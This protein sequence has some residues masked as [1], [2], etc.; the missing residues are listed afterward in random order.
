MENR[1][2]KYVS[3]KGRDYEVNYL[4]EPRWGERGEVTICYINFD[5]DDNK[6][7]LLKQII[8]KSERSPRDNYS[9]NQGYKVAYGRLLKKLVALEKVL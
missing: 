5:D 1:T 9:S 8:A 4:Q 6:K 3:F 7:L 2:R